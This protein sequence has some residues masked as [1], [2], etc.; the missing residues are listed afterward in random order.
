V[1]P[2]SASA[3]TPRQPAKR[4][5]GS[6]VR[7]MAAAAAQNQAAVQKYVAEL[8]EQRKEFSAPD[9]YFSSEMVEIMELEVSALA[10]ANMGKFDEAIELLRRATSLEESL[11]PPSGPPDVIKPSHELLGEVLLRA[12]RPAEAAA[13]FKTALLRQPNRPRSLL[14][15][16][17]A[18]KA[19]D[20]K[21]AAQAY[22]DYLRTQERADEQAADLNEARLY[23]KQASA[24]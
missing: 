6:Y 12:N 13:Q 22:A 19:G 5:Y 18:A 17:R 24:R 9:S 21:L 2:A 16:A 3:Q 10:K 7:G 8:R 14:G 11:R 1:I 4:L 20:A 15:L 23:L